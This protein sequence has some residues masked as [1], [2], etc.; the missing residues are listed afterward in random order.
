MDLPKRHRTHQIEELS[1]RFFKNQTPIEWVINRFEHDYGTDYNCEIDERGGMSGRNFTIQLK[2]KE[3]ETDSSNISISNIKK[4]TI[5]RWFN[6]L[7]PTM[8]IAYI[9]DEKEAFWIWVDENTVDLTK[10]N[11]TFTIKISR[12][13]KLSS[14]DWGI[15]NE[16]ILKVFSRK[17]LLYKVPDIKDNE[18]T[19]ELFFSQKYDKALPEL[20]ELSRKENSG[21]I[22]NAIAICNYQLYHYQASL[23]AINKALQIDE[24]DI[25]YLNKAATLTEKGLLENDKQLIFDAL[26]IYEKL[27]FKGTKDDK[28]YYNYGSA[29][30]KIGEKEKAFKYFSDALKI[31]PNNPEV[32]TNLGNLYLSLGKYEEQLNCYNKALNINPNLSEALFSKGSTLF[33]FFGRV[34]EGLELMLKA[35]D[36]SNRYEFDFPSLYFWISEAYMAK[37]EIDKAKEWNLKGLSIF[38]KD[39][40]LILQKSRLEIL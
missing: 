8:L 10:N 6:R 2:G 39:E 29:L 26:E 16:K 37:I 35:S 34:D 33:R 24:N 5:R 19:W 31:N 9:V 7:E 20:K 32:W 3:K 12:D 28:L 11:Q 1:E 14:I 17:S 13:N 22:W 4:T 36:L 23:I 38:N 15:I 30:M 18:E 25:L 40:Y 27:L 21:I